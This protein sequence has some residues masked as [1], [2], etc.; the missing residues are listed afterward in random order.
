MAPFSGARVGL[1]EGLRS[2]DI[3]SLHTPLTP[4]TRHLLNA[5]RLGMMK[6]GAILINTA[7][8]PVIDE[9]ALAEVLRD[10]RIFGAGLDVYEREPEVHPD[11]IGLENV[12]LTP[13]IGSASI[14]SRELMREMVQENAAA[15]VAG[16]EPPNRVG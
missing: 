1:E 13:H 16:R 11:L 2:A 4:E 3:V 12:V 14:K 15:I 5:R 6:R 10:G 9:G 8:G 7:R